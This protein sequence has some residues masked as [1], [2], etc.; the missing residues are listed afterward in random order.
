MTPPTA[1]VRREMVTDDLFPAKSREARRRR[2]VMR[3]SSAIVGASQQSS[4]P[5]NDEIIPPTRRQKRRDCCQ[6]LEDGK[7]N[8]K[9]SLSSSSSSSSESSSSDEAEASEAMPSTT[10]GKFLADDLVPVF[11]S[12]SVSGRC[13]EME[14]AISV[15]P[16]F[17]R[18]EISGR[19]P[20]HFFAVYDG[21]GGSHVAILCQEK[22]HVFLEEELMRVASNSSEGSSCSSSAAQERTA[23]VS[24]EERWKTVMGRCFERMD[25][26]ALSS[27]ACG[28]I[29]TPC[30][31]EQAGVTSEIVGSTAVVAVLTT[32]TILVAN[33]GDSRAVLSR[34]G[35]AIPLSTDHKPD[36]PDELARIEAAG[37]RVIYLS[38]ARVLGILAM[39]RALGDKYLKPIVISEPE[40]TITE[41]TPED[42][43]LILAS[44]GLWDV[45]SNELAC[46]VARKC[47]HEEESSSNAAR[48]LDAEP[49]DGDTGTEQMNQSRC[50]L[51][52]A[53]LTRLALGRKS[54]D[55]ISV[56]VI[57]LKRD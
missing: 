51:A 55:N 43:C 11:G 27:C 5:K 14:D 56:I 46:E 29:T 28:G 24:Q 35:R 25:E 54:S 40:L 53:L 19:R 22:M 57:D 39:S 37:G 33:C 36:R 47:L 20:L 38:G 3:R 48:I 34:G 50:S 8:R 2:M 21:H 41:R 13:R 23:E 17:C 32:D 26:V 15:Q 44:D 30:R 4:S 7:R 52:A 12:I 31:C 6:R 1:E 45:L 9:S 16:G 42:E 18:P 10:T 49:P